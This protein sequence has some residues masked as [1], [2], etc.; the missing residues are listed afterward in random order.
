[1]DEFV[2]RSKRP[3]IN[4]D[5]SPVQPVVL[6]ASTPEPSVSKKIE[7]QPVKQEPMPEEPA[8]AP[9]PPKKTSLIDKIKNFKVPT[10]KTKKQWIIAVAI[11]A[12][13]LGGAG[14]AVYWFILRDTTPP[15]AYVAPPEPE[16]ATPEKIYSRLSGREVAA[17][18]NERPI[19]AVQIENSPE[20]RPQAGLKEADVVYEAIAEGGITRFNAVYQDNV[21]ANIGPIRS[22][23]PYYIDW[24]LPYDAAIVHAGG[25][26]EALADVGSLSLKDIDHSGS[27]VFRRVSD[28]YAPHNLYSRGQQILDLMGQRGYT[29]KVSSLPRKDAAVS[30]TPNAKTLNL[31][32]SRGLYNVVFTYD[33]A[34]NSYLRAQGGSSHIDAESKTQLAPNVVVVPIISRSTHS[35]RVHTVYG[36]VGS[37]KLYVFQDGTVT[38]GTWKKTAR[39]TQWEL[40]DASGKPIE[41]NRGQ[42]WF[43]MIESADRVSYSP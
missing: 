14:F 34:T 10:P 40:L 13:L 1:M 4:L 35:D 24:F 32:V 38:E 18:V 21:P 42:T 30:E 8:T 17:S 16:P 36:T 22:L 9:Q 39:N 37:G 26:A 33:P 12:L 3:K 28:R 11:M 6:E 41:L 27:G 15:A 29:S 5:P 31:N 19:Y 43:T 7:Y 25:S 20:A 2:R 23:R